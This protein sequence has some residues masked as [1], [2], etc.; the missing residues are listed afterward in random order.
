MANLFGKEYTKQELLKRTGNLSQVAGIKEYTFNSGR[1]KGVEAID[2]N[3]GDLQFTILKS[4]CLDLGQASFRGFPFGYLSKS[5]LR[6]PEYFRENGAIGYLDGFY[7]GLL[8]T[9]GLNNIGNPCTVDGREYGLHGEIANIPAEKVSVK[10]YWEDDELFFEIS[11]IVRHSRFYAEDL[12]L[13]RTISTR[14]GSKKIIVKDVIENRDFNRIPMMLLYHIN[15]GFPFLDSQSELIT[16]SL[17]GSRA[18]TPSAEKGLKTF[19][20]FMEPVDGIE[21]ECFYHEFDDPNKQAAVCLFNPNLGEK[22]MGVYLKYSLEELPVFIEWKMMRSREYVCGIIPATNYVEGRADALE[23]NRFNY[24]E[25]L[26]KKEYTL[27][28]GITDERDSF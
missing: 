22:G 15:L 12:V 19:A 1:A 7:G 2:V 8:T 14:L 5:G 16:P 18:R 11:G 9:C 24:I 27:E 10:E 13:E 6:S 3:A 21:E 20:E 25:P 28:I 17:K 4:R 23:T 26:E